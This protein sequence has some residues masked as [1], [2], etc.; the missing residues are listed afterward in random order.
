MVK[1]LP[2]V[3]WASRTTVKEATCN[4]PLLVFGTKAVLPNEVGI[5][6]TRVTYYD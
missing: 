4:T 3:L 6:S 2:D 1:E 5:P